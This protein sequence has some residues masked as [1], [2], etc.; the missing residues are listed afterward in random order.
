MRIIAIRPQPGL[1]RTLAAG[2]QVG[3]AI[4]GVA[5]FEVR[6]LAWAPPPPGD[7]DALLIGSPNALRHGGARLADYRHLPVHAVGE[8]TAQAARG[9]GFVVDRVGAGG[10]QGLLD[11]AGEP[12]R[13]LRLAGLAHVPLVAPPRASIAT[14]LVYASAALPLPAALAE[15]L[16]AGALVLLHSGEAARHLA[17]ECERL[18]VPRTSVALAALGQRIAEQAGPGWAAV[19]SAP[20]PRE[21]ALLA[22]VRDMWHWGN[23]GER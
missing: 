18:G 7:F 23:A 20:V 10:L 1:A 5:L 4:E 17:G 6:P 2:R 19:A 22:L 11:G 14:C 9:A 3:L 15:G 12:L 8:E 16:R 21:S 13:Y